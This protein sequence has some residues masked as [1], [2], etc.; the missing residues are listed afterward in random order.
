MAFDSDSNLS[1]STDDHNIDNEENVIFLFLSLFSK[2]S[3]V[4][5][6]NRLSESSYNGW[7]IYLATQYIFYFLKC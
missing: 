1:L 4:G 5:A 6:L 3:E 7:A 2:C